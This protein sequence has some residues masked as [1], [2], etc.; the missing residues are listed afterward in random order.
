MIKILQKLSIV[1]SCAKSNRKYVG[2]LYIL[3]AI[4]CVANFKVMVTKYRMLSDRFEFSTHNT[5]YVKTSGYNILHKNAE[6]KIMFQ[7]SAH[8][9]YTYFHGRLQYSFIKKIYDIYQYK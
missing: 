8:A 1:L 9:K 2:F 7:I 3:A 6:K 4:L 5:N